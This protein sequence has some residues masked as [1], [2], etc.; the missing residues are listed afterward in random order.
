ML[1]TLNFYTMSN[2]PTIL[3]D[4]LTP[5][6]RSRVTLDS[7]DALLSMPEVSREQWSRAVRAKTDAL[8]EMARQKLNDHPQMKP[9]DA[10][11]ELEQAVEELERSPYADEMRGIFFYCKISL[12]FAMRQYLNQ[13]ADSKA[14]YAGEIQKRWVGLNKNEINRQNSLPKEKRNLFLLTYYNNMYTRMLINALEEIDEDGSQGLVAS[15]CEELAPI[16]DDSGFPELQEYAKTLQGIRRR[17]CCVGKEFEF[18]CVLTNGEK[19]NVKDLRGKIVLVNF[20][21]T[22]CGPCLHEFP[23]MKTQYEKFRDKGYEMIALSVDADIEVVTE[24]QEQNDY[25]WLVGSLVQSKDA[26]LVDYHAYY[27]IQSVPATFLLDR[28]GKV[29]FRM[30]GSDDERLNRELEKVFAAQE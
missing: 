12:L 22:W 5:Q 28:D 24:F 19:I 17:V 10:F 14:D 9:E 7:A 20:W 2:D 15:L 16:L 1:T 26:G 13:T 3:S 23:N 27:G 8:R 4:V 29:L 6:I 25:P 18:E 30:V 21:A 11:K